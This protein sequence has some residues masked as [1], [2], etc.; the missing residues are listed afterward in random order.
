MEVLKTTPEYAHAQFVDGFFE[1]AVDLGTPG[2]DSQTDLMVIAS[3]DNQLAIIAVE[4]KV[5][6]TFG[7]LVSDWNNGS[8]GKVRRL[9]ALCRTLGI[10]LSRCASLRYQLLH[11]TASAVYEA[12]R[13]RCTHALML[14]HSFSAKDASFG[15]F[16]AFA[17]SMGIPVG[18]TNLI[19]PEKKC[20]GVSIRLAWVSDKVAAAQ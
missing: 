14:V 18:S 17:D 10:D 4:G 19:S 12:K 7:S 9:E 5:E 8:S 1:R 15:D 20:D 13:Y 11:R 6:E 3:I 16:S 2:R